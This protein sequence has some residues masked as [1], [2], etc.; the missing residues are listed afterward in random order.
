M[1]ETFE[2]VKEAFDDA[3]NVI[4]GDFG[5]RASELLVILREL[6]IIERIIALEYLIKYFSCSEKCT[7]VAIRNSIQR[8]H[9]YRL[10]KKF[11]TERY[12]HFFKFLRENPSEKEVAKKLHVL[13]LDAKIPK[14]QEFLLERFL[15]SGI[16]P[17]RQV[18]TEMESAA[19]F[20]KESN[21]IDEE[22]IDK[23]SII[24]SLVFRG[25]PS[26]KNEMMFH[27]I[28]GEENI[29]KQFALFSL[30]MELTEINALEEG[31]V[32]AIISNKNSNNASSPTE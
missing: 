15:T 31:E 26:K 20:F 14:E 27:L 10:E 2:E 8:D 12:I 24:R 16:F 19:E 25:D 29:E 13:L 6:P 28:S 21:Q 3:M 32:S 11:P 17:Y 18:T 4:D 9:F 1:Y 5:D 23:A 22:T 30:A 7:H